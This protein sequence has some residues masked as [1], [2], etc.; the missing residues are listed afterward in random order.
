[1]TQPDLVAFE[2]FIA[3]TYRREAKKRR[4]NPKLAARLN[5]LADASAARAEE[6]RSGPLFRGKE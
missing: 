3:T 5:E 1:M 6:F 4:R 2:T